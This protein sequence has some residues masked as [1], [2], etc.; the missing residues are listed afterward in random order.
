MATGYQFSTASQIATGLAVLAS[1]HSTEYTA[2]QAAFNASTGHN[3]D[4][5]VGGGAQIPTAGIA[6]LAVTTAKLAAD[7]V[8][9]AKIVDDAVTYAKIQNVSATDKLLGRSSSGAGN[10]EEITCTAAGRALLDDA[11]SSAQRT[12]LGLGGLAILT[13]VGTSQIDD[14]AVTYAKMQDVSATDKVLG[15]SSSG[16][17]DVEEITCTSF[18][19][20]ILDDTD[21]AT[22]RSTLGVSFGKQTIWIPAGAMKPTITNGCSSPATTEISSS[23]PNIITL[24]FDASTI[25]YASLPPIAMPKSWNESTITAQFIWTHGSTTTNYGVVWGIE[26]VAVGNSD[27]I[28]ASF[29]TAVTVTDTGGTTNT[30]YTA[31]ET[32]AITLA[33]TPAE[34]DVAYIRVYRAATDGSDTLAVDAK[35]LGVKIFIT[36]NASNDS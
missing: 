18:A 5:T 27:A 19:R 20:T 16:S 36:T 32:S 13:T 21:A 6:D 1:T 30:Q 14:G 9:T 35:L 28:G 31:D 2:I 15:R 26:G 4:G 11:D 33:G 17:G 7:A 34:G 25:E 10:V 12:T 23:Q 22:A 8:T 24:D 3:H 29:G